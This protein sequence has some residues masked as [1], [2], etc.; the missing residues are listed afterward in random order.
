MG[1]ISERKMEEVA[2]GPAGFGR[3]ALVESRKKTDR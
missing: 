3:H 2:A 1:S